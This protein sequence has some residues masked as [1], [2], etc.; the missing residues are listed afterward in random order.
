MHLNS[1]TPQ[2]AALNWNWVILPRML[3]QPEPFCYINDVLVSVIKQLGK[4]TFGVVWEVEADLPSDVRQHHSGPYAMKFVMNQGDLNLKK[5]LQAEKTFL[6]ILANGTSQ[7]RTIPN[8]A[9]INTHLTQIENPMSG[10]R[11]EW[12]TSSV[13]VFVIGMKKY[14]QTVKEFIASSTFD[15]TQWNRLSIITFV[16]KMGVK[17]FMFDICSNYV[18]IDRF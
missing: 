15:F 11:H 12:S 18:Y 14:H 5:Q 7:G 3:S 4:G 16:S 1:L 10:R 17:Q 2:C 6:Q 9:E 13:N 8:V